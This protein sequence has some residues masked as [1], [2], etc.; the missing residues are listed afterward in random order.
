MEY[1]IE[2]GEGFV[3]ETYSAKSPE[4]ALNK[5]AKYYLGYDK[6]DG[7][8]RLKDGNRVIIEK[9]RNPMPR[10][11]RS[12]YYQYGYEEGKSAAHDTDWEPGEM[13]KAYEDDNIG[14]VVG[15]ILENW[16]QMAGTIYYEDLSSSKL[17]K[18][19]E[20]FYDGFSHE[21][22]IILKQEGKI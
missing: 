19:E 18:F 13:L 10:K 12:E 15:Q 16:Q 9:R 20:G 7:P 5:Y 2:L 14:E 21:V 6:Y 11:S 8:W 22:E 4:A 17:D 1:K 3:I